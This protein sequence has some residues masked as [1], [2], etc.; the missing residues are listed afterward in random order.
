M[1]PLVNNCPRFIYSIHPNTQPTSTRSLF[2]E[3]HMKRNSTIFGIL[4]ASLLPLIIFTIAFL[5]RFHEIGYLYVL[6]S[7][8]YQQVFPKMLSLCVYP[9][10]LTFYYYIQTN[11]LNT[12]RGMLI[13]TIAMAILV[14]ILY[15]VFG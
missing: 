15:L 2:Y 10:G 5:I 8:A 7:S 9:N 3:S 6:K 4:L 14:L 1:R 12:M 11:R 13:G